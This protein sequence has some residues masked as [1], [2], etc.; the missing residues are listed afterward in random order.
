MS[1][2]V[3]IIPIEDF[4]LMIILQAFNPPLQPNTSVHFYINE[5]ALILEVRTLEPLG[6][7]GVEQHSSFSLRG[8]GFAL[9]AVKPPTHDEVDDIFSWRGQDVKVREKV[10]VESSDPKLMAALAKLNSIERTVALARK[11]LDALMGQ[12]N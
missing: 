4:M 6:P 12:E 11:A 8:I 5:A 9:G 3:L 7:G 2:Y 1:R 10:R